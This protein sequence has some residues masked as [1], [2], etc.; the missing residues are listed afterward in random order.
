M[1]VSK[2]MVVRWEQG[3]LATHSYAALAQYCSSVGTVHGLHHIYPALKWSR[4]D[5]SLGLRVQLTPYPLLSP[6]LLS[7]AAWICA[8]KIANHWGADHCLA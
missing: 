3:R 1:A 4:P 6:S 5:V 2:S 8:N 7:E